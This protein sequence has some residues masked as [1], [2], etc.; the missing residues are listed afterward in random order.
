MTMHKALHL[1]DDINRRYLSRK[2]EGRGLTNIKDSDEA[3]IKHLQ[4]NIKKS[5]ERLITDTR[6][7]TSNKII[8]R[9]K[10]NFKKKKWEEKQLYRHF[11]RR[12]NLTLEDL[13]MAKK[14]EPEERN[15]ISSH[16]STKQGYND[17][18]DVDEATQ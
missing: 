2:V 12:T 9:K 1:K 6:N 13:D 8:N 17:K 14:R 16:R 15:W 5:K 18:L 7:N 10:N 3:S 11:K 4:D